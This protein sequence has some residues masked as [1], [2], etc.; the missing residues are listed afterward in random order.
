MEPYYARAEHLFWVHGSH[1]EDPF[2][3]F[4]REPNP[5]VFQKTLAIND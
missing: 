5:T 2:L 4:S 3:A 1:G